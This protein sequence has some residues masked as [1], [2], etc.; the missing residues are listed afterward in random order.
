MAESPFKGL[1]YSPEVLG[2]IGLLTAGLSGQ[3]P[4]AALPNL[5]QG[6]KTA[7]M[8][9][10][11]EEEEEKR[12]LIKEYSEKVPE[13]DQKLFKA[14][15][16]EYLKK[17]EFATPKAAKFTTFINAD[18]DKQT[19]NIA[20]KEGLEKATNLT[21]NGYDVISQSIAGKTATDVLGKSN[22]TKL[23]DTII[24][25]ENLLSNLK[26]QE[27]LFDPE[28]LSIDGKVKFEALKAKDRTANLTGFELTQDERGYLNRYS[29]WL[30]TNQQYFNDYRKSVTGV[31]AGE[32][33]IG[34]I[35][36]SIPSDKDTPSTF[37]AKLK[38]QIVIQQ[39]L[40]AN[41]QEFLA[42]SGKSAT[43]DN[44]VY[45][46]DYLNYIKGKVKP[47]GEM[48]EN[49]MIGYKL[50]GY[51]ADVIEKLLDDE[52]KGIDWRSI[53]DSYYKAKKGSM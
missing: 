21:N 35:Q 45:T 15:P 49:L 23:G 36:E 19:I 51:Q 7:S 32:K 29:T 53:F 2:G 17:N 44:G 12:K 14:F 31:A 50:D 26:R 11:M 37:K 39:K 18:G 3:D 42:T 41:A 6:M 38:N 16:L 52:Y 40:I 20:T 10:T 22:K 33:E 4:G 34:W 30:Q 5:L 28:F 1:L 46:K 43:D 48:I 24:K 8:F 13:E 9:K 47:N 27:L 25:G